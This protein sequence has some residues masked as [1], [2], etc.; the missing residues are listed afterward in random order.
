MRLL[1]AEGARKNRQVKTAELTGLQG[2]RKGTMG[3]VLR[4]TD[5]ELGGTTRKTE[6][7]LG[8]PLGSI[9]H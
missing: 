2:L 9:C 8:G 3:F 5:G 6:T 1:A 7:T 4:E